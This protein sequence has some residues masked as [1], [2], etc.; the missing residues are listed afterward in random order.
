M[1]RVFLSLG[2]SDR[3]E[4]DVMDDISKAE[5]LITSYYPNEELDF[6]HNY[7]YIGHSRV[8]CLGQ[9]IKKMAICD[10]VYFINDWDKH[11]GCIIEHKVCELYGIEH[12]FI[13]V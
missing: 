1:K 2:F 11:K 13:I 3:P 4:S 10:I 8:E 12:K 7:D 5:E 6:I 9:A